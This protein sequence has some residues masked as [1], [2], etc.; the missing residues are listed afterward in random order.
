[1]RLVIELKRGEVP[2]V[3]LNNLYKQTQLQDTFGMNMVA[4]VDGRPQLLNLKQLL[5]CFLS[6]R[7]EVVTR[8]TVF[9]LTQGARSRPHPRRPGGRAVQRRRN[10]RPDQGG[11]DAGRCQA[12]A[13][14]AYLAL[15]AGRGN[16]GARRSRGFASR[17][18]GAG[19][20]HVAARLPALRRAGPGDS[21]TALA[22]PDRPGA[23]QDRHRVP[24]GDGAD[25]RPAR[26]PGPSRA[27][28]RRSSATNWPPSRRSSATSAA[29]RSSCR[30][31]TSTSKT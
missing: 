6:H 14:G 9:E 15:D 22:A 30:R 19:I 2:E 23:G 24:R 10:H 11:A 4:L 18:P 20:R 17:R 8:R 5:E 25:R 21:R 28:H 1:M 31:P 13:D 29:R 26:H 12:R 27:H 7:R 3:I 16:A